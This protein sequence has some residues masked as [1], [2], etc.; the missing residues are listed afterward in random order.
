MK[1][2]NTKKAHK[3]LE[4]IEKFN[5]LDILKAD[6]I[7]PI[8]EKYSPVHRERIFTPTVTLSLFLKQAL[9][10][11]R[12]C[13]NAVN[14]YI[15]DN[16]EKLPSNISNSTGSFCRSRKRL[17]LELIQE[18]ARH[19]GNSIKQNLSKDYDI[20]GNAYLIDGTTFS[21]PDTPENQKAFPQQS[22]Q[23]EGLGF[24][25][26]R[27]LGIFCLESGAAINADI[28]A[29]KGKGTSEHQLLRNLLGTFKKGDL[30]VGDALYSSFWLLEYCL[31]MGIDCVFQQNGNRRKK[32]ALNDSESNENKDQLSHYNKPQKPDW[33]GDDEY[34][35][36]PNSI[37]VREL[38][39]KHKVI[40]TTLFDPVKAPP[41]TIDEIYKSRW[42][43]ELD[44][45]NLK[46]TMSLS[47]LS[48]KTPEMCKK[49]IWVCLLANN[50]IRII[51]MQASMCFKVKPRS[52]SFKN[53][54]QIW[55]KVSGCYSKALKKI[56]QFLLFIAKKI[57]GN[58]SG[59]VEPRAKKRRASAYSLLMTTRRE[60][61][62]NIRK[63]GHP[64]K[65][66]KNTGANG[67]IA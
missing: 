2:S 20:E 59:R 19:T 37:A 42:H 63:N 61:R 21:L 18:L 57:V 47:N 54:L 11:D 32:S 55:N 49:E 4:I 48:C 44:F 41:E 3:T 25:I 7:T 40:V 62:D 23:A 45:R 22:T 65:K 5:Y 58:R 30:I 31:R 35:S 56:G 52:I 67:A 46:A 24:P 36:I 64:P 10:P 66:R 6:N 43:I 39:M 38:K 17:P 9:S 28:A 27:A 34:V 1:D 12:S 51:M 33:M 60:A 29:Y 8:I 26:C 16:L 50:L 13:A 53:T 14:N 15:I